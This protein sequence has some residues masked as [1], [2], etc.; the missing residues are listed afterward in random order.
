[1]TVTTPSSGGVLIAAAGDIACDPTDAG[2]NGG[3]G[4]G[5]ACAQKAT[6][7]LIAGTPAIA[8]VLSLGDNQYGCGGF[9][10]FQQ[11]FDPSW[12]RFLSKIH[13]VAGNHEYQTTAA[14]TVRRTRPGTSATSVRPPAT[15]GRTRHGTPGPGT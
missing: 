2:F 8:D 11:S 1:M 4:T 14:P 3:N 6:S 7:D 10:A 12:G 5:T 9:Q 13:P 15:H